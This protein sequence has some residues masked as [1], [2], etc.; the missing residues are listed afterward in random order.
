MNDIQ[1]VEVIIAP[2][3]G[4]NIKVNGVKGTGCLEITEEMLRLLGED[5]QQRELTDEYYLEQKEGQNDW[6]TQSSW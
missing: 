4:V 1:E 6:D 3:G 2:D 5:L